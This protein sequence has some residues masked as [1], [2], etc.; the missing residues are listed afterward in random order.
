MSK[1]SSGSAAV[2]VITVLVLIALI[3]GLI[4]LVYHFTDHFQSGIKTFYLTYNGKDIMTE[5]SKMSFT[6][7]SVI[8]F[9]VKYPFEIGNEDREYDVRIIPNEEVSFS[10][11]AGDKSLVWRANGQTEDLSEIFGLKKEA[12]HFSFKLPYDFSIESAPSAVYPTEE[13]TLANADLLDQKALYRIEVASFNKKY[14]YT[15]NFNVLP[16][17]V[18]SV[19]VGQNHAI[20]GG[21]TR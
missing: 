1:K 8:R 20:L 21:G 13:L 3:G 9:D 18:G 11:K 19:E 10:Y 12:D 6:T 5:T 2:T 7:G 15:I 4:G 17:P 14:I 16:E